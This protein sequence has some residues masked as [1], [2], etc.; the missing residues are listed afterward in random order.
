MLGDLFEQLLN[1][2][3]K[4]NEGQ[5]FT[6]IPITRFIWDSLPVTRIIK[7]ADGIEFPKIID[8][9]CGAG[10]FLTQGFEA[11]NAAILSLDPSY[12]IDYSWTEHNIFGVEKDYRLA[13]VSKI[14][15]FM[16]GAGDGNIV[17]GDGLENYPDKD[18]LPESFDIL[19]ANPP[20]SVKA[21]KPHLKLKNNNLKILDK[22]SND[23]SEIETLFVERISQLVKHEKNYY[24]WQED[25]YFKMY[26]D[27]FVSSAEYGNKSKQKNF[28]KLSKTEQLAWYNE[29]FYNYAHTIEKEK[30]TYFALIYQQ[31]TLIITAPDD[32]KAQEKFLGYKWSN[33]K[34]QE[35]IQIITPGGMLYSE[36]DRNTDQKVCGLIRSSFSDKK[37]LPP[38]LDAYAYYLNLKDMIDFSSLSFGT[39]MTIIRS[40][41]H[42]YLWAY[43]QSD[44][45][46]NQITNGKTMS[47]NQITTKMLD[48]IIVPLP[49][50][51]TI[52]TF[53]KFV[54][55][56]EKKI[57]S[58]QT[59][60]ASLKEQQQVVMNKHFS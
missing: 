33:R 52:D 27:A 28:R 44:D 37:H 19:V 3:F 5:F 32:N 16:H 30:L 25:E 49:D 6:P 10:H 36:D 2:G 31:T 9:A 23:G 35:G 17:F 20:Y 60:I 56:I 21:F 15:L 34:G 59:I 53:T 4:Q 51:V 13:C 41:Y 14:S 29:H 12:P 39:F 45:F 38:E 1:K 46:R 24:E 11:V 40:K 7:K 42:R 48:K 18:I 58:S 26:Y 47:I 8:Y 22:I 57:D 54:M 55:D 50:K 43:L